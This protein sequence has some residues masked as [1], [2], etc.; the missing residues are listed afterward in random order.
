LPSWNFDS[1]DSILRTSSPVV[2]NVDSDISDTRKSV[3]RFE[4]CKSLKSGGSLLVNENWF[5]WDEKNKVEGKM[6]I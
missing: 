1:L 3:L 6:D 4:V 2:W 5:Q